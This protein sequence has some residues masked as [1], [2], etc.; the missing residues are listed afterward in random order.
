MFVV[1]RNFNIFHCNETA[2]QE[3]CGTYLFEFLLHGYQ[4]ICN[5]MRIVGKHSKCVL[6]KINNKTKY[7]FV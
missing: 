5:A 7:S 1:K 2:T 3:F 4:I 6:T